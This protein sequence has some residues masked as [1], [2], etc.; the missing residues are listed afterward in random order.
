MQYPMT[1]RAHHRQIRNL[2]FLRGLHF[3]NGDLVMSLDE[4]S[5]SVPINSLKIKTARLAEQPLIHFFELRLRL[6]HQNRASLPSSVFS[7]DD[8]P[9]WKALS[10]PFIFVK[11]TIAELEKPKFPLVLVRL[12][13]QVAAIF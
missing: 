13:T 8:L 1:V 4:I 9:F 6:S 11:V 7:L 3:A 5:S 10:R 2:S 12:D